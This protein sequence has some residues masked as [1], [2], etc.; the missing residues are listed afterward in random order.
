LPG[1]EMYM[2]RKALWPLNHPPGAQAGAGV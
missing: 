2:R 1:E